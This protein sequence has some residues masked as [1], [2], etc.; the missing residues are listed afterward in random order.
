[1]PEKRPAFWRRLI[2]MFLNASPT[3]SVE[4]WVVYVGIVPEKARTLRYALNQLESESTPVMITRQ[5][6]AH[7]GR[8]LDP[9]DLLRASL[10]LS[11]EGVKRRSD[12]VQFEEAL[13]SHIDAHG[14]WAW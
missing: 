6:L 13:L 9:A 10:L 7:A 3:L 12:V 2:V 8:L 14:E 4:L 11:K 1:M 5:R